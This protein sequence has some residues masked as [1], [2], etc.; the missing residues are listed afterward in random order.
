MQIGISLSLS[1]V[2]RAAPSARALAD[3]VISALTPAA[4]YRNAT[5]VISA[6]GFASEWGDYSGNSHPLLQT[7]GTNQPAYSAGV[8]TG[9]GVDNFM[10]TAAFTLN[11]PAHIFAVARQDSWTDGDV[12]LA[13]IGNDPRIY[14]VTATPNIAAYSG[15]NVNAN[16]DPVIGAWAIVAVLFNG[17]SSSIK[18]DANAA[19]TGNP[20]ATAPGGL[21]LFRLGAS[22]VG[23]GNWSVKEIVAF[24]TALSGAEQTS[25]ITALN[26]ALTVF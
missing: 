5:G 13:G 9:D 24:P 4:W 14:Q 1:R 3:S 7:V 21:T 11:Q 19:V 8:F 15:A 23:Y 6:G 10:Q 25:V 16:P 26:N 22:S 12:L 17:A 18:I 20:G 2:G